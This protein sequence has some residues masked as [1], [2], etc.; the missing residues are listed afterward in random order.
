MKIISKFKDYY[1]YLVG[2]YGVDEKLIL[3]RTKFTS[4][5]FEPTENTRLIF[6]ICGMRVEGIYKNGKFLYGD[7]LIPYCYYCNNKLDSFLAKDKYFVN[8]LYI[9][10]KPEKS[11]IDYNEKYNCPILKSILATMTCRH[12]QS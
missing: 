12:F 3:D 11:K 4:L 6:Y 2:I 1:D 8:D 10:K 7:D 5:R 9:L